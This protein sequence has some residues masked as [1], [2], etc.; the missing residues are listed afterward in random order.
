MTS[1]VGGCQLAALTAFLL[2]VWAMNIFFYLENSG[3]RETKASLLKR[4]NTFGG[5][6][7]SATAVPLTSVLHER[8]SFT[9]RVFPVW[10]YDGEFLC[11]QDTQRGLISLHR[12]VWSNCIV[13][14]REFH[15]I[16]LIAKW[17]R[18]PNA[19]RVFWGIKAAPVSNA[20][21]PLAIIWIRGFRSWLF[22]R[23]KAML[24][25]PAPVEI[26]TG[27]RRLDTHLLRSAGIDI[28]V[29][30]PDVG[31]SGGGRSLDRA[32]ERMTSGKALM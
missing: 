12:A 27:L 20:A 8:G 7:M 4:T 15:E 21:F 19:R 26:K 5:T 13:P 25:P 31:E 1:D 3:T 16:A 14:E 2:T 22:R 30:G 23:R 17:A 10:E 6:W 28:R 32:D 24:R 18:Q 9:T 29:C 11:T